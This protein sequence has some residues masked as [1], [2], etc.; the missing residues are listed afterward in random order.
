MRNFISADDAAEVGRGAAIGVGRW[1]ELPGNGNE[2]EKCSR[3]ASMP[4]TRISGTSFV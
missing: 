2:E 4:D 3:E 1:Y